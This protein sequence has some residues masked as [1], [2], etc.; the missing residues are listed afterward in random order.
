LLPRLLE[1]FLVNLWDYR[2]RLTAIRETTVRGMQIVHDLGIRPDAVYVDADHSAEAVFEDLE[3]IHRLFPH[4]QIIG[5]D[6][7]WP[8]VRAGVKRFAYLHRL[9]V[10]ASGGVW[11]IPRRTER[12]SVASAMG[13]QGKVVALTLFRRPDYTRRVIDALVACDGI[14]DY[15]VTFHVEPGY[16]AVLELAHEAPFDN[17]RIVENNSLL[18]CGDNIY[19]ALDDAFRFADYVVLLEDDVVPAADCMRY[20]EWARR[21]YRDDP[22]VFSVSTYSRS[23]PPPELY[24]RVRRVPWFNCWGWATWADRWAEMRAQ[25]DFSPGE[26]WDIRVNQMRGQRVQIEPHLARSQ[27]IGA[28]QGAHCPSPDW[29]RQN[30]LNEFGAWSVDLDPRAEFHEE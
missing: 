12:S 15:L 1:T 22:Q 2:H 18:G 5:D 24:Y 3:C 4:V 23:V 19:S 10:K 20:F 29:H 30:V 28:E 25:W 16:P 13:H 6:W 8:S 27:N 21:R 9:D 7:P 26:S 17:K 14:A 11:W